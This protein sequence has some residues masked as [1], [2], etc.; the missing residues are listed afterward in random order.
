[1]EPRW[2]EWRAYTGG[3][4]SDVLG[5]EPQ[6]AASVG[7]ALTLMFGTSALGLVSGALLFAV[8]G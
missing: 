3:V 1:V 4:L 7:E 8:I 5:L 2:R 6:R